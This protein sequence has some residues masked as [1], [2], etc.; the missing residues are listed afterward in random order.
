MSGIDVA[1]NGTSTARGA[2]TNVN[3]MTR[4]APLLRLRVELS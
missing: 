1:G 3:P 2:F 4:A